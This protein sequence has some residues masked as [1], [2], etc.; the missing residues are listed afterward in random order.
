MTVDLSWFVS[1][2]GWPIA[3]PGLM[4]C[5]ILPG[6]NHGY[7]RPPK[8]REKANL[9]VTKMLL[10]S[11]LLWEV[12]RDCSVREA[13]DLYQ[14]SKSSITTEAETLLVHNI[15]SFSWGLSPLYYTKKWVIRPNHKIPLFQLIYLL[16]WENKLKHISNFYPY[17]YQ[18]INPNCSLHLISFKLVCFLIQLSECTMFICFYLKIIPPKFKYRLPGLFFLSLFLGP[19]ETDLSFHY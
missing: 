1:R 4:R 17:Y 13:N 6:I 11:A 16:I 9:R 3:T 15:G 8:E 19:V 14:H 7:Q 2:Y 12:I 5:E 10:Y 18:W